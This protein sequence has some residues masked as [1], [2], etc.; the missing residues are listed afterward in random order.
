MGE[1]HA[2][3]CLNG[4]NIGELGIENNSQMF[5]T[6]HTRK[7]I[8][9]EH[10]EFLQSHSVVLTETFRK[11]LEYHVGKTLFQLGHFFVVGTHGD[12]HIVRGV[13]HV[14]DQVIEWGGGI[15]KT[16]IVRPKVIQATGVVACS[17]QPFRGQIGHASHIGQC[18]GIVLHGIDH[19]HSR[20]D[21]G[22]G[23][24]GSSSHGNGGLSSQRRGSDSGDGLCH[25]PSGGGR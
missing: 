6:T 4:V 1:E 5:P 17:I 24:N 3:P 10:K 13:I 11:A 7:C 12:R 22:G 25:N 15:G 8:V 14:D 18:C 2:W 16:G 23:N 21:G 19:N 20:R 9:A